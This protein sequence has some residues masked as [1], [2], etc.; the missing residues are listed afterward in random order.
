MNKKF[1]EIYQ[2]IENAGNMENIPFAFNTITRVPNT[3]ASHRLIRRS[4]EK[5]CQDAVVEGL[6]RCYFQDGK[7]IGDIDNLVAVAVEAGLNEAETAAY[8]R[9][10][11][12]V[13]VIVA[14][15]QE[16]HR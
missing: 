6:F 15:T 8:L 16:A 2:S 9:V 4:L 12:G 14:E 11:E 3:I 13:D 7:D 1:N 5:N 10:D